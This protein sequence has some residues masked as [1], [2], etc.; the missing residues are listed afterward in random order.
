MKYI[1]NYISTEDT[2]FSL[3][4][5]VNYNFR[6]LSDHV[7]RIVPLK[8]ERGLQGDEGEKG[9]KGEPGEPSPKLYIYP[10]QYDENDPESVERFLKWCKDNGVIDGSFV[11][12]TQTGKAAL[13]GDSGESNEVLMDIRKTVLEVT[14]DQ[15]YDDKFIFSYGINESVFLRKY[16][17]DPQYMSCILLYKNYDG[18]I[19]RGSLGYITMIS[20]VDDTTKD[21]YK[22]TKNVNGLQFGINNGGSIKEENFSINYS[23]FDPDSGHIIS[24]TVFNLSPNDKCAGFRF[25]MPLERSKSNGFV[26]GTGKEYLKNVA[27]IETDY[28]S[29]ISLFDGNKNY[30]NIGLNGSEAGI[31]SYSNAFIFHVVD[32]EDDTS[33]ISFL[34]KDNSVTFSFTGFYEE[35]YESGVK[36]KRDIAIDL[37]GYDN[38][39]ISCNKLEL[40]PGYCL[41]ENKYDDSSVIIKGGNSSDKLYPGGGVFIGNTVSYSNENVNP[42]IECNSVFISSGTHD[43]KINDDNKKF[44]IGVYSDD[45]VMDA[46]KS[47]YLTCSSNSNFSFAVSSSNKISVNAWHSNENDKSIYLNSKKMMFK[48]GVDITMSISSVINFGNFYETV[49]GKYNET[50]F[51]FYTLSG[52][53]ITGETNKLYIDSTPEHKIQYNGG[54][55]SRIYKFN[56]KS[57][58]LC[59]F[60]KTG[61]E[62]IL[63]NDKYPSP[64]NTLNVINSKI[65][66]KSDNLYIN[67][68]GFNTK[69]S[70]IGGLF[71]FYSYLMNDNISNSYLYYNLGISTI[72]R[73]SLKIFSMN[74]EHENY[75]LNRNKTMLINTN[76]EDFF[77]KIKYKDKV[78][79]VCKDKLSA[80]LI[81][82]E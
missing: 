72:T 32:A 5:K 33:K 80:C 63:D 45:I 59:I 21:W 77:F 38:K 22:N 26:F 78:F 6:V 69:R 27:G 7:N 73:N 79:K 41:K 66:L 54:S 10:Y 55:Y 1:M 31:N 18:G 81:A 70:S 42:T 36:K 14:S 20:D 51:K 48:D 65:N 40:I 8:G 62:N 82:K 13:I 39:I 57:F 25:L 35:E 43:I 28:D 24:D 50:D 56:G 37:A 12:F 17:S 61:S 4:N 19:D 44:F 9:L 58:D 68:L 29:Y 46:V 11:L 47:I 23:S 60:K 15:K 74:F 75:T 52:T 76:T 30:T 16:M 71:M 34:S 3:E 67:T 53:V 2:N 64:L 49:E